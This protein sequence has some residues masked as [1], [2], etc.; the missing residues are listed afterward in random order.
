MSNNEEYIEERPLIAAGKKPTVAVGLWVRAG[1]FVV[2][3]FLLVFILYALIFFAKEPLLTLGKNSVYLAFFVIFCY[4]FLLNGP[5]GRGKTPGKIIFNVTV[6]DKNLNILKFPSAFKRAIIQLNALI[7]LIFL[8]QPFSHDIETINQQFLNMLIPLFLLAFNLGSIV[9]LATYP[10]K[11]GIHDLFAESV[12]Q[13][14]SQKRSFDEMV[15]EIGESCGMWRRKAFQSGATAGIVIVIVG[16][17]LAYRNIYSEKSKILFKEGKEFKKACKIEGFEFEVN[18]ERRP[19]K[20]EQKNKEASP[21]EKPISS[22]PQLKQDEVQYKYVVVFTYF[23]FKSYPESFFSDDKNLQT[24]LS[25]VI[26]WVKKK[27]NDDFEFQVKT[28][29]DEKDFVRLNKMKSLFNSSEI[30]FKFVQRLDLILYTHN[31]M[32]FQKNIPLKLHSPELLSEIEKQGLLTSDAST[33]P[34]KTNASVEK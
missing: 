7:I 4:F 13:K 11:Q 22:R 34:T 2:D 27:L 6:T 29:Y 16:S 26:D 10:L 18:P 23:G 31:E 24:K 20:D 21:L 30:E 25:E 9:F 28:L 1:A 15:N 17:F 5:L 8:V 12:V 3:L 33:S 14:E 32:L 19:I